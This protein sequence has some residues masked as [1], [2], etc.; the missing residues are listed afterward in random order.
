MHAFEWSSKTI[1]KGNNFR[2]E[3]IHAMIVSYGILFM[4]PLVVVDI[5]VHTTCNQ[6]VS[7]Y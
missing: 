4:P 1:K 3:I 7:E 6:Q 2:I 5:F